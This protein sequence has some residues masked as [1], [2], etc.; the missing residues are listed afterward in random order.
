MQDEEFRPEDN[1]EPEAEDF[2][3]AP[4][5]P[6]GY[7]QRIPN[8]RSLNPALVLFLLSRDEFSILD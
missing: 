8:L 4:P 2:I 5:K 1:N 3:L 7:L 6:K